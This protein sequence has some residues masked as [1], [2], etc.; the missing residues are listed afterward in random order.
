MLGICHKHLAL[1]RYDARGGKA[2][3]IVGIPEF[4]K[5]PFHHAIQRKNLNP[6]VAGVG[7]EKFILEDANTSGPQE[8]AAFF[9]KPADGFE[10]LP[11]SEIKALNPPVIAVHDVGDGSGYG[12]ALR[13]IK[14][15]RGGA[16]GK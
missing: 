4:S 8:K 10:K 6:V 13:P 7:D 3:L 15:T 9:P 5:C 11:G 12:Y 16:G 14:L 2:K 1:S